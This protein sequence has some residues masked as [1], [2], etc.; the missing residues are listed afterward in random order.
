FV[1]TNYEGLGQ[2]QG[3]DINSLVL[4][5]EERA[6]ATDPVVRRLIELIP[7]ANFF[8]ADGTPRFVGAAAALVNT[9]HWTIDLSHNLSGNDRLHAFYGSHKILS[10]EPTAS[11]NSIPGFGSVARL[12]RSQLTVGETHIFSAVLVNEIRFGRNGFS[13]TVVP[14]AELNPSE[15]GIRNGVTSPIG[16]PQ[17]LV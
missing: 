1:L 14:A 2:R 6:A 11:G 3:L 10:K 5:D 15:F 13:G 4:S 7:R 9:D 12:P 17:M 16:L 8:D